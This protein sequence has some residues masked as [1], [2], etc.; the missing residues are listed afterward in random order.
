[1]RSEHLQRLSSART[2]LSDPDYLV[3]RYLFRDLKT[4][5]RQFGRGAVLDI[6]C[7]NKPYQPL[8]LEAKSY[9]GCDIIQSS[10]NRVD[11]VCPSTD[12]PLA[13]ASYDTI[14][15]TQV[16]EHVEDHGKML[17]EAFRLLKPGGNII[18]SAPMMWPH[19]EEPYDFFRFTRYGLEYLFLKTGFS[20]ITITQNGGK[21]ATIGQLRQTVWGQTVRK[22]KSPARR[23]LFVFYKYCLKYL[24]NIQYSI[25][26]SIEP[27]DDFI[28]LN[29]VVTAQKS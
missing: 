26:E 5:I 29:Y 22:S 6:G 15:S 2:S 3:Y 1:M 18:L 8:F 16:L 7:G 21:W 23:I 27:D 9:T 11:V 4:A 14:F 20:N 28:T 19:H 17:A 12:I 10:E 24:I 13:D 25:L